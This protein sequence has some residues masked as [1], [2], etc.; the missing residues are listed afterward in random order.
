MLTWRNSAHCC[1]VG[2][3]I[4][5]PLAA[6]KRQRRQTFWMQTSGTALLAVELCSLVH[7]WMAAQDSRS[8]HGLLYLAAVRNDACEQGHCQDHVDISVGA[9]LIR[10]W[11]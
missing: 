5:R 4:E 7:V 1:A 2:G 9:H 6:R 8:V 3:S 10:L 11:R